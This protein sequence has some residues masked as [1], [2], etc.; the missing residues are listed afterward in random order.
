MK[1]LKNFLLNLSNGGQ[2]IHSDTFVFK[3]SWSSINM[4]VVREFVVRVLHFSH[5]KKWD[6]FISE[7]EYCFLRLPSMGNPLF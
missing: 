1:D 5:F 3:I 4:E 2:K 6:D 7:V